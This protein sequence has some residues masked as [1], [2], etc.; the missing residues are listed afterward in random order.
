MIFVIWMFIIPVADAR[1]QTPNLELSASETHDFVIEAVSW[2]SFP[3]ACSSGDR[4]SG[5][6]RLV[7]NGD[8]FPGDQTKYDNWLLEGID[9]LI[10]DEENYSLWIENSLF[11]PI[12]ERDSFTELEWSIEIPYNGVWYVIYSNDSIFMKQ[13]QGSII[14]SR[15]NDILI[16]MIGLFGLASVLTLIL[17]YWKK[18]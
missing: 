13:I 12:F 11:I 15:P 5:E 4:L 2:K 9:F 14:H 8:L 10:L 18:K 7:S 1:E 16:E 6:F 3:I 17:I